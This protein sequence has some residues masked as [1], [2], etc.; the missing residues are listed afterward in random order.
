[1][2]KEQ[3]WDELESQILAISLQRTEL[4]QQIAELKSQQNELGTLQ[5]CYCCSEKLI[6]EPEATLPLGWNFVNLQY[7][8]A[9]DDRVKRGNFLVCPKHD[10]QKVAGAKR[11]RVR[12]PSL[13]IV[14]SVHRSGLVQSGE[15]VCFLHKNTKGIRMR[16]SFVTL[17][18]GRV[19][20]IRNRFFGPGHQYT[21]VMKPHERRL[22]RRVGKL[23]LDAI[24]EDQ[25]QPVVVQMSEELTPADHYDAFDFFDKHIVTVKYGDDGMLKYASCGEGNTPSRK[26]R[27]RRR[28]NNRRF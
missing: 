24:V 19:K 4:D 28:R 17:Q 26:R 18:G 2:S 12:R 7:T 8:D 10:P 3:R 21:N 13:R 11:G 25:S 20:E 9:G 1:M 5:R 22:Q 27:R 6:V 23:E 15:S 14:E 16:K